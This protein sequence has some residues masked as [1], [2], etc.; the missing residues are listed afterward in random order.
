MKIFVALG[1]N[2]SSVRGT[3]S[4]HGLSSIVTTTLIRLALVTTL[5]ESPSCVAP[6]THDIIIRLAFW[7]RR[8]NSIR[9]QADIC[10]GCGGRRRL[11]Y[12]LSTIAPRGGCIVLI[13]SNEAKQIVA[14]LYT[15][16]LIVTCTGAILSIFLGPKAMA[17][18]GAHDLSE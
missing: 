4:A 3:S 15:I 11:S 7:S 9:A 1:T 18:R 10:G 17:N 8:C 12:I 2:F 13:G 16:D 5:V 6:C 14:V